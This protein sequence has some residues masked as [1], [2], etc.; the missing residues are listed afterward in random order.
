MALTFHNIL[1]VDTHGLTPVV[2]TDW[3]RTKV[4]TFNTDIV[5]WLIG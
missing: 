4:S 2:L 3:G 1:L 5:D